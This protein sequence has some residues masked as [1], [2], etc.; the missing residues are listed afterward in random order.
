MVVRN[1][2]RGTSHLDSGRRDRFR[3]LVVAVGACGRTVESFEELSLARI[4]PEDLCKRCA[5]LR[6][7]GKA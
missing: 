2:R 7:A 6:A 1:I 4:A 3:G 5:L